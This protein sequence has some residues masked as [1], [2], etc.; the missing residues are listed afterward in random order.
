VV[1]GDGPLRGQLEDFVTL[2][3][4]PVTF[5]GFMNQGDISKGYVVSDCLVLPS[6]ASETWGLV[7]NEAF[8]FK[9]PAIVSDVVGCV[10]D[11][12]VNDKTGWD[13]PF[14]NLH[15]LAVRMLSFVQS[16]KNGFLFKDNIGNLIDSFSVDRSCFGLHQALFSGH[17][18]FRV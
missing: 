2:N 15:E 9:I 14:G 6:D 10:P 13:Y 18:F 3:S 11:L 1:V 5:F 16:N 8:N 12:I 7:V 17:R 4:L